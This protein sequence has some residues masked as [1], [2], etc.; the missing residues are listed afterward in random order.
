MPKKNQSG[1]KNAEAIQHEEELFDFPHAYGETKIA[2]LVRDPHWIHAYWEITKEKYDEIKQKLHQDFDS[3]HEIL[4]VYDTSKEP[5]KSFDIK[6]FYGSRNWYVNVPEA[7]KTYIIDIGFLTK[8][9]RFIMM[10]RSNAVTT[11]RAGMS[12]VID[13]EW[14]TIDFERIYALSGGF[15]V[16]KS[17]GE[18]KKLMEKHLELQRASGWISSISSYSIARQAK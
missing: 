8:D 12:D 5:W 10:A 7:N 18:I 9:G 6:V 15:G 14:M 1:K 17:S 11:P 16:G 13:E 3:S 4:R 2:L